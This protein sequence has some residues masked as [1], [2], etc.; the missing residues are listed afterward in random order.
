MSGAPTL[1]QDP[2]LRAMIL[3]LFKINPRALD[4]RPFGLGTVFRIDPWGNCATAFHVIEDMLVANGDKAELRDDVR[5]CALEIEGI[6]YGQPPLPKD[7]WRPLARFY[8]E[9]GLET[10]PLLHVPKKIRNLTE[11]TNLTIP[12]SE[13]PGDTPYLP[14]ALS[15]SAPN[16]G[17]IV[18]G[19]GF[20][21][22]DVDQNGKG[23]DRPIQQ[24]LYESSGEVIELFPADPASTMPWP[25]FRVAAEWPSGMSGG[26]V[27]DKDGRVIGI[28]SRGWTGQPDSTATHF[29]GWN[30]GPRTFP[31]LDASN[32]G[33]FRCF[34]AIDGEDDV[35]FLSLNVD[36]AKEFAKA[37]GYQ[38]RFVSCNPTTRGWIASEIEQPKVGEAQ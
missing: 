17:D 37:N 2:R 19:Y 26:P 28:I 6:V 22:L 33:F 29:A 31:T 13:R 25:R 20:A 35:R 32:P 36:A 27:L 21:G 16:V 38:V 30:I 5:V 12:R 1:N 8:S 4:D 11:L 34:A 23:D 10:S 18:T 9:L 15:S 24:Y 7:A 3:P 14:M